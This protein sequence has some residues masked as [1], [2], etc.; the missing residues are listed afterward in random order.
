MLIIGRWH[1]RWYAQISQRWLLRCEG[2]DDPLMILGLVKWMQ[3]V[4]GYDVRRELESWRPTSGPT[5][6]RGRSTTP[7]A[8]WPRRA[9]W[10]RWR[11]SRSARGRRARRTGSRP[12]ATPSSRSCCGGT[13][14][15][16]QQPIDPFLAGFAFLPALPRREAA[17][18]LR[19]RA[20]LLRAA[21]D[22]AAGSRS[23]ASGCGRPS[24]PTWRGC[25]SCRGRPA[26]GGDRLVRAGRRRGSRAVPPVSRG[27]ADLVRRAGHADRDDAE[28]IK[29]D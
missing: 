29:F 10:R 20:R 13:G 11:P 2:V 24:R 16:Y 1:E 9:C 18:A 28:I 21:A 25:S 4:H 17:A 23:P 8:S 27:H 26:R 7:C 3:P 6:R 22:S 12:R 15:S 5:S 14:G 19:N